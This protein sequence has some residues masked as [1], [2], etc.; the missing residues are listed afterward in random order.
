MQISNVLLC[1]FLNVYEIRDFKKL[2][3]KKK[4]SNEV[5]IWIISFQVLF[6][7]INSIISMFL[8]LR[9]AFDNSKSI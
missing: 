8:I 4:L 3:K 1:D 2:I 9:L 5:E 6:C 7:E